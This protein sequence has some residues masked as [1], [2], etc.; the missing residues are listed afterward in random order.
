MLWISGDK[1]RGNGVCGQGWRGNE[2]CPPDLPAPPDETDKNCEEVGRGWGKDSS[3]LSRTPDRPS[4][5]DSG[6]RRF[7]AAHDA[8]RDVTHRRHQVVSLKVALM[9]YLVQVTLLSLDSS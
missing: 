1:N 3:L 2:P 8:G 4:V 6:P 7:T 5:R 9:I